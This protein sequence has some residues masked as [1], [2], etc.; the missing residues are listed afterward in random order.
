MHLDKAVAQV[1]RALRMESGITQ[2]ELGYRTGLDPMT[3]SRIERAERLPSLTTLFQIAKV[4]GLTGEA[5]MQRIECLDPEIS[6]AEEPD[7][8]YPTR[9]KAKGKKRQQ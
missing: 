8:E 9:P 3:V 4:F 5:I 7:S 1:V 2:R 6:V